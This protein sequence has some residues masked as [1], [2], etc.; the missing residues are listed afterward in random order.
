MEDRLYN[1]VVRYVDERFPDLE[2]EARQRQIDAYCI[3]FLRV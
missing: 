2:G 3:A 1:L